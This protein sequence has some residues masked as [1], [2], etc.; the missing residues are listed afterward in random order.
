MVR[1]RPATS[2]LVRSG[3]R[4]GTG[5]QP[6]GHRGH[7]DRGRSPISV[8]ASWEADHKLW[9]DQGRAFYTWQPAGGCQG[10]V[11]ETFA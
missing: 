1:A 2:G 3:G 6:A 7:Q 9:L 4:T 10:N 8:R 11:S 5:Q